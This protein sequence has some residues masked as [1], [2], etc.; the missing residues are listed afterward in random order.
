MPQRFDV[1]AVITAS[2]GTVS[3]PCAL[4]VLGTDLWRAEF[5]LQVAGDA[6]VDLRCYLRL[7]TTTLSE[8]WLYQYLP[9]FYGEGCR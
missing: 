3:R 5:D 1:D 9:K 4:K 6:P 7:G 8:T 2:R